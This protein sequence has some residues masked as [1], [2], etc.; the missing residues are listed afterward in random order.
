MMADPPLRCY[1]TL[2]EF[3]RGDAICDLDVHCAAFEYRD[4]Y[5]TY[6]AAHQNIVSSDVAMDPDGE[7]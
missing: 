2:V 6:R 1:G 5:P 7:F 3:G 4:D